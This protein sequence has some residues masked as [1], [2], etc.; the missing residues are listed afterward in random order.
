MTLAFFLLG[1]LAGA[2]VLAIVLVPRL[3]SAIDSAS[4]ASEVERAASIELKA[5]AERHRA[6]LDGARQQALREAEHAARLADER[7]SAHERQLAQLRAATEEKIA[8]VSGNRKQLA[9]Q[10]KATS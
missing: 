5:A 3:R 6:E 7:E 2:A 8:L 10:M 4:V 1:L 9:E